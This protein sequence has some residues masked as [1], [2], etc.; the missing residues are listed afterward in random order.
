MTSVKHKFTTVKNDLS[1]EI[2]PLD[3]QVTRT[4][5]PLPLRPVSYLIVGRKG[6]G[7]STMM[8][9]LL[10]RKSSPYYRAFDNVFLVS[11][12]AKKDAKFDK[13]VEELER[14]GKFYD[15]LTEDVIDEI[16]QRIDT[17]NKEYKMEHPK[18]EPRNLLIID[19]CI[20]MMPTSTTKSSINAIYTNQRHSKLTV[21][22][23]SQ[24]L[25]KINRLIRTN[26]DMLTFF[27]TDNKKEFECI[28]DEWSIKPDLLKEVYDYAT[29]RDN[30]FLHIV[31][32]R[33]PIFFKRFDKIVMEE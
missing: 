17:F 22:T 29:D 32:G 14:D 24:Q 16:I 25:N 6:S 33:R 13:L 7:K 9:N 1:N 11:P 27:P 20:H 12:T 4:D 3:N 30:S 8:L 2:Q 26:A 5:E 23:C 19:D 21:W 15:E 28:Q 10:K 31:F 18:S